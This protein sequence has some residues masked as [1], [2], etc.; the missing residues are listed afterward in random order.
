MK[1]RNTKL[2]SKTLYLLHLTLRMIIRSVVEA[3]R[4]SASAEFSSLGGFRSFR[5]KRSVGNSRSGFAP[6]PFLL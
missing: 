2:L 6:S 4:F 5:S 1:I 3:A